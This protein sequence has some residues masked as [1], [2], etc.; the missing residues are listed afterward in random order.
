MIQLNLR[1]SVLMFV[2]ATL[3]GCVTTNVYPDGRDQVILDSDIRE[4]RAKLRRVG[5]ELVDPAR[6]NVPDDEQPRVLAVRTLREATVQALPPRRGGYLL[7]GVDRHYVDDAR[8]IL[9]ALRDWDSSTPVVVTARRNPY[10][11]S[12]LDFWES[13]VRLALPK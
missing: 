6:A 2:L 4:I 11:P 13:E 10:G 5:L 3:S 9:A 1:W 12:G 7:V 8:E